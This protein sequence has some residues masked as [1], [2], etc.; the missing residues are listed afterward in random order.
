MTKT[1]RNVALQA[2]IP[3]LCGLVVLNAYVVAK[4]IKTIALDA[5]QRERASEINAGISRIAFDLQ[6]METGQRGY[7]LTGDP[8]YLQPYNEAAGRLD[9]RFAQLRSTLNGKDRLVEAQ[10]ESTA[11]AKIAEMEETIRLRQQGYRHRAFLVVDSNRGKELMEEARTKLAAL[12]AAQIS[13]AARSDRAMGESVRR[14]V[15]QSVLASGMLLVVTVITFLALNHHR[16]VL[17]IAAA[18]RAQELRA[19]T[20]QLERVT[21]TVLN[22]V[23]GPVE[24]MRNHANSLLD[25]YGGFLPHQGQ[26]K[27]ERIENGAGQMMRVLDDLFANAPPVKVE[28]L[29]HPH[30]LSA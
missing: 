3:L 13:N 16:R 14:A 6:A 17:A 21:S 15:R 7:L 28:P 12:S 1:L 2:A 25:L 19:A 27:A 5:G 30:T 10:L 4:N 20:V 8:S 23:R 11:T 26:E 24:E 18:A 29:A 9:A 22:E